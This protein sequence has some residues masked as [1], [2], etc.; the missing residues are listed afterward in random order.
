MGKGKVVFL[1]TT[2]AYFPSNNSWISL[3]PMPTARNEIFNFKIGYYGGGK[4]NT[5]EA[6]F[7]SNNS[8]IT[9]NPMP[10]IRNWLTSSVVNNV[11]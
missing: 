2:E 1:N 10:T 11:I 6:Y 7:P 9:L 5:T 3:T 4:L 8:W